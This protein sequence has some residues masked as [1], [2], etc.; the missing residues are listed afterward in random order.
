MMP[1]LSGL[2]IRIL[3]DLIISLTFEVFRTLLF[4]ELFELYNIL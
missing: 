1:T 4:I 3:A 2:Q